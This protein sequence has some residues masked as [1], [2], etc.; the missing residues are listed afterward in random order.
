M[1]RHI[2]RLW[3]LPEDQKHPQDRWSNLEDPRNRVAVMARIGGFSSKVQP[4]KR[5]QAFVDEE[6][7]FSTIL[8]VARMTE[9]VESRVEEF[10]AAHEE[11]NSVAGWR[12]EAWEKTC[13]EAD[14]FP[15]GTIVR[16]WNL[17][18]RKWEVIGRTPG[19]WEY[20]D[21]IQSSLDACRHMDEIVAALE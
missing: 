6:L 9:E 20:Q 8:I 10:L 14:K 12:R 18:A 11:V 4:E 13:A 16:C 17:P 19:W 5:P 2:F 3:T 21:V 15:V 1:D 7:Y